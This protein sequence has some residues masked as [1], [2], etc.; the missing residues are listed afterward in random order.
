MYVVKHMFPVRRF[1]CTSFLTHFSFDEHESYLW[2]DVMYKVAHKIKATEKKKVQSFF[3]WGLI[4]R[5]FF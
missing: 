3:S 1:I 2:T 4:L 5:E